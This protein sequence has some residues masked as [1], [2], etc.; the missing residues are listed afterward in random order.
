MNSDEIKTLA[1]R[2]EHYQAWR[3]G[4]PVSEPDPYQLGIDLDAAIAL[5]REV[6][7]DNPAQ[8]GSDTPPAP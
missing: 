3:R 5:M 6:A 2:L 8:A 4:W 1:D 7:N